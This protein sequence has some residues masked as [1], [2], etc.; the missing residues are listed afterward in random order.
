[1]SPPPP[2]GTGWESWISH[3]NAIDA[4]AW[5]PPNSTRLDGISNLDVTIQGRNATP[6]VLTGIQ[7]VV[8]HRNTGTIQGGVVTNQ[9]GGPME[10]RWMVVNLDQTPPNIVVSYPDAFPPPSGQPWQATPIKFPYSV[11][12][13][14]GEVFKIITYTH[15]DCVWYAE[16]FWSI[17]GIN[18]ESIIN[19]DGKPFQTALAANAAV[20]YGRKGSGWYICPAKAALNCALHQ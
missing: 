15:S 17:N 3:N 11:T 12:D 5:T 16:L 20:A 4:T 1:V 2:D 7:F 10:A 13:T 19:D 14:D 9:C 18:G 8:L 6:V